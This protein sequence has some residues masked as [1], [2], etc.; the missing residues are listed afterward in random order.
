M[1]CVRREMLLTQW[2]SGASSL[3]ALTRAGW[4]VALEG[5][6][7][8]SKHSI[9]LTTSVPRL[10]DNATWNPA[11]LAWLA[12]SGET[13]WT[14]SNITG[15]FMDF[16]I[17]CPACKPFIC[18]IARSRTMTSGVSCSLRATASKPLVASPQT[19]QLACCSKSLRKRRRMDVSSSAMRIRVGT[20]PV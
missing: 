13:S 19:F 20:T 18:G 10:F 12:S 6:W 9:S 15:T 11:F 3:F 14:V 4:R 8:L 2:H 17:S 7:S 16:E 5:C 1:W